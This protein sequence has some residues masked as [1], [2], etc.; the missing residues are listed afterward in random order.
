MFWSTTRDLTV[1]I[2]SDT[3]S[4]NRFFKYFHV[5]DN[6]TFQEGDKLAKISPVYENM[7]KRLRQ[8][9]IFNEALSIGECM[10][11]YYGHHSCKMFI[12]KSPF[13]LASKYG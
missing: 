6:M 4:R 7:G 5:V 11:P 3:M 10:V 8:W 12:K 2:A 13:A 1:S 9:G